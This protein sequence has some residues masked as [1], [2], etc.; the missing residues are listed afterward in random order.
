[1]QELAEE[2]RLEG[3]STLSVWGCDT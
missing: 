3:M 1:M 2:T